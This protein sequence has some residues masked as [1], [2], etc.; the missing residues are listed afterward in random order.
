MKNLGTKTECFVASF[1]ETIWVMLTNYTIGTWLSPKA[2][3]KLRVGLSF[4]Q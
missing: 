2:H 3:K 4:Q 1:L